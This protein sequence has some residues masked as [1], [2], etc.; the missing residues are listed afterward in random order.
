[1][2]AFLRSSKIALPKIRPGEVFAEMGISATRLVMPTRGN[3]DM[4]DQLMQTVSLLVDM[5][6]QVDRSDQEIRVLEA[7]ARGYIPKQ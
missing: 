3:L 1:M 5:K 2:P 7:Q 6:R 4:Y